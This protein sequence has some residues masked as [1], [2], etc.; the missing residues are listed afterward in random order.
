MVTGWNPTRRE[1]AV[2]AVVAVCMASGRN[3][4]YEGREVQPGAIVNFLGIY[5][6]VCPDIR[7][8]CVYAR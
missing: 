2:V 6:R 4:W 1:A 8:A 3:M 7:A 5:A